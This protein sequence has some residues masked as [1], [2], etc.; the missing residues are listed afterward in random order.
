MSDDVDNEI[1]YDDG[2]IIREL[3]TAFQPSVVLQSLDLFR[4][5]VLA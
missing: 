2:F 4:F 1:M 3:I 5:K